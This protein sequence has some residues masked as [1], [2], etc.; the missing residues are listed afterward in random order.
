M[1][2]TGLYCIPVYTKYPRVI[3][4]CMLFI[5]F[6]CL[7]IWCMCIQFYVRMCMQGGISTRRRCLWEKDTSPWKALR[8][9][10]QPAIQTSNMCQSLR[11]FLICANFAKLCGSH[12][13]IVP[14]SVFLSSFYLY[15]FSFQFHTFTCILEFLINRQEPEYLRCQQP[16]TPTTCPRG[17]GRDNTIRCE[18]ANQRL[19]ARFGRDWW[20]RLH[21]SQQFQALL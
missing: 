19:L 11:S 15:F 3:I 17:A 4:N 2:Y 20:D 16:R 14:G 10:H 1:S 5:N 6:Q 13:R 12:R 9:C 7:D 8:V 18:G 21:F